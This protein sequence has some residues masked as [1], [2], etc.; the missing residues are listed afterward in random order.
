[1][2]QN[3]CDLSSFRRRT[4]EL[5]IHN[6]ALGASEYREIRSAADQAQVEYAGRFLIELLQNASDAAS[7]AGLKDSLL[8]VI[9]TDHAV[10]VANQGAP[11]DPEGKGVECIC[12][13][14]LTTKD[15]AT[16]V[17]NKGVG[18]KSVVDVTST[19]EIYS[20]PVRPG[21][22]FRYAFRLDRDIHVQLTPSRFLCQLL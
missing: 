16:Y 20:G 9:R 3:I 18:F 21:L 19:P 11:F 13:F 22:Q 14:G 2:D 6:L 4:Y 1:M 8:K 12:S 5:L 15:A 7:K 10:Y 17:G